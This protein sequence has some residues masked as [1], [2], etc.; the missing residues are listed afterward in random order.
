MT[1]TLLQGDCRDLLPIEADVCITDPP[2][3]VDKKGDMLGQ[4]AGN[5]HDKGTHTRGYADHSRERYAE[6][7]K[8]AFDGIY[9]SLPKGGLMVAFGGARTFVE[10]TGYAEA[11]GF[12]LVD[13]LVFPKRKTFARATSTL[14]PCHE[15]AAF[16]RK[17]GGKAKMINPDR[18]IG[19]IF[20]ITR[21][22]KSESEHPTT[23]AQS[24]MRRVLEVFTEPGETVLDPFAGSG[25]T[26][27]AAQSMGRKVIGI[28]A[29][30]PYFE[31]AKQ[32]TQHACK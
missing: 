20:D 19:N 14:V 25:S 1:V 12:S 30:A 18:N 6:L 17:P 23:K 8:P 4:L 5:Y 31:I 22:Q 16:M 11:A 7:M 21:P 26:L 28:E 15:L 2:Y 32:R 13:I 27:V 3:A 9:N 24:W 29:L 10:M